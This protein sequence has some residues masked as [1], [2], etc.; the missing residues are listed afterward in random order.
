V[1]LSGGWRVDRLGP[2]S[3]VWPRGDEVRWGKGSNHGGERNQ[4]MRLARWA[5]WCLN[6][7]S[8]LAPRGDFCLLGGKEMGKMMG[9]LGG[10]DG[11][12]DQ[13]SG[14][15]SRLKQARR[16]GV[17]KIADFFSCRRRFIC[18]ISNGR[19]ASGRV[20][21]S[22]TSITLLRLLTM[23]QAVGSGSRSKSRG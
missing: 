18:T 7:G 8:G 16:E 2:Q 10:R 17:T 20:E 14:A 15:L 23:R 9:D 12:D 5:H 1:G 19:D 11:A 6:K 3:F 13:G 22:S 21:A 4:Q